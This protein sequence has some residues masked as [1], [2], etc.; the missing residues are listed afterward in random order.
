ME[1]SSLEETLVEEHTAE[2]AQLI[3]VFG[4]DHGIAPVTMLGRLSLTSAQLSL[5][6]LTAEATEEDPH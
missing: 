2:L 5:A 1:C 4:R 3:A 6:M